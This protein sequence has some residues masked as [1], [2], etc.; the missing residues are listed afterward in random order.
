MLVLFATLSTASTMLLPTYYCFTITALV[1]SRTVA[2]IAKGIITVLVT[3][4]LK[5]TGIWFTRVLLCKQEL[6]LSKQ[7]DGLNTNENKLVHK[8][9]L[10]GPETHIEIASLV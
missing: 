9:Y 6:E 1:P 4:A 10:C 3:S 2:C 7:K 5:V 8:Q